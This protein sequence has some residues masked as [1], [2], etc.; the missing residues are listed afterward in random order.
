MCLAIAVGFVG[1]LL[2]QEVSAQQEGSQPSAAE[3]QRVEVCKLLPKEEVKKYLPW[4]NALD[5]MPIEEE[6]VGTGSSCNY[7]T[8]HVQVLRFSQSFMEALRKSG[9]LD[10]ISGVGDEAYF[11]NNKDRY[12]ELMVKV[13]RD[14]D[15]A[16]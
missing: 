16:S 7:P 8:V 3:G 11:R 2:S 6:A 1:V 15:I 14:S 9:P 12:A 4:I 10:T 5:Q 13:G